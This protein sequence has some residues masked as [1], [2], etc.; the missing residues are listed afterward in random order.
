MLGTFDRNFVETIA[1]AFGLGISHQQKQSDTI[2]DPQVQVPKLFFF[3]LGE[4]GAGQTR[5][6][7]P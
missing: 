5:R 6:I 2:V 4:S 3:F 1:R 7:Q